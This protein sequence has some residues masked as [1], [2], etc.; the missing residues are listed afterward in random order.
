VSYGIYDELDPK[1]SMVFKTGTPNGMS[2]T[3]YRVRLAELRAR[4]I[5][6]LAL[7]VLDLATTALS[8]AWGGQESNPLVHAVG[9]PIA[10]L[11]K[12]LVVPAIHVLAR[13]AL[14]RGEWPIAQWVTGIACLYMAA[15]VVWNVGIIVVLAWG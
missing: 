8:L 13:K 9:W 12:L 6:L 1:R 4:A 15:V 11:A 7:M 5:L 14:R 3:L 10:I 2:V